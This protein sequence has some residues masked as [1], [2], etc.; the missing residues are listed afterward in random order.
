MR[1]LAPALF[2][3]LS[4]AV[5]SCLPPS[6]MRQVESNN[7][8]LRAQVDSL[9][10]QMQRLRNTVAKA[11]LAGVKAEEA[12]LR[13]HA[14][15][16]L[17]LNQFAEQIRVLND[18]VEDLDNRVS[19]MPGKL[20]L[21]SEKPAAGN[22]NPPAGSG[23]EAKS[24]EAHAEEAKKLY[25][26]AYQDLVRGQSELAREGFQEFLRKYPQ[27]SLADNAQYWI[28]ESY[29]AQKNYTR[30]AAEFSEVPTK[31]PSSDKVAAAMLKRA[32]ALLAINRTADGKALL[33]QVIKQ[34]PAAPEA[35]LAKAKLQE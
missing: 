34:F 18:R 11:E 26:T 24:T 9:R 17:R 30:A 31:Y 33:E 6:Q 25:D 27:S 5:L 7:A 35:A 3:A 13:M 8:A 1:N 32:Y 23:V 2:A 20:R 16:E 22:A 21:A 12:T 19:N 29:Y 10:L 28:G 15:N 4:F 14:D